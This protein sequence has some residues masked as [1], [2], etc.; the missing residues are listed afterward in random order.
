MEIAK[1]EH[2]MCYMD[3]ILI[4]AGGRGKEGLLTSTEYLDI[5]TCNMTDPNKYYQW[6]ND[7]TVLLNEP[8]ASICLCANPIKKCIYCFGGKLKTEL[9]DKI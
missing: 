1:R 3:P 9:S 6:I 2:S 7:K 8:K 4:S 5:S